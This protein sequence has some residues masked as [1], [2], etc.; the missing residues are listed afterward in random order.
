MGVASAAAHPSAFLGADENGWGLLADRALYHAHA[1]VGGSYG[2]RFGTG[3][4]VGCELDCEAGTLSFAVNGVPCGVAFSGLT[5]KLYPAVGLYSEGTR[6]TLLP[7]HVDTPGAGV[8]VAGAPSHVVVEELQ[9]V[10]SVLRSRVGLAQHHTVTAAS[11]PPAFA[12]ALDASWLRW[13]AGFERRALTKNGYELSF[14]TDPRTIAALAG[15]RAMRGQLTLLSRSARS[16]EMLATTPELA[17]LLAQCV[18][19]AGDRVRFKPRPAGRS[20]RSPSSFERRRSGGAGAAARVATAASG[21]SYHD[22]APSRTHGSTSR[23]ACVTVPEEDGD[24]DEDALSGDGSESLNGGGARAGAAIA[25]ASVASCDD[26]CLSLATSAEVA[27]SAAP[28]SAGAAPG[29]GDEEHADSVGSGSDA[30]TDSDDES[31]EADDDDD[32]GDDDAEDDEV[33]DDEEDAANV[34]AVRARKGVCEGELIG[35]HGG[36]LWM[37]AD[38]DVGAW[39]LMTS[40]SFSHPSDTVGGK[41]RDSQPETLQSTGR[42]PPAGACLQGWA[43]GVGAGSIAGETGVSE[44]ALA[45]AGQLASMLY[46]GTAAA[47]SADGSDTRLFQ[48]RTSYT[49]ASLASDATLLAAVAWSDACDAALT[50]EV[51]SI[52]SA[53]TATSTANPWNLSPAVIGTLPVARSG[54][55]VNPSSRPSAAVL[56]RLEMLLPCLQPAGNASVG[57][58]S[59]SADASAST[60]HAETGISVASLTVGDLRCIVTMAR[61]AALRLLNDRVRPLLPFLDMSQLA[62]AGAATD[63]LLPVCG[64]ITAAASG[65]GDASS[66][67]MASAGVCASPLCPDLLRSA[68]SARHLLFAHTKRAVLASVLE[69]TATVPRKP[70]DEFEFPSELPVVCVNRLRAVAAFNRAKEAAAA[71]GKGS[72]KQAEE[73]GAS[74][75]DLKLLSQSVFGQLFEALHPLSGPTLRLSFAHPM[76]DG[77]YRAFRVKLEGEGSDDYS[78]PYRELFETVAQE[79]LATAAASGDRDGSSAS[80]ADAPPSCLLPFFIPVPNASAGVGDNR[81]W[82]MLSPVPCGAQ[83]VHV[84]VHVPM[85]AS[86]PSGASAGAPAR[87]AAAG[88]GGSPS[89]EHTHDSDSESQ[90]QLCLVRSTLLLPDSARSHLLFL[91]QLLGMALRSRLQLPL[92]LAPSF[93]RS[94]AMQ[95]VTEVHLAAADTALFSSL[96]GIGAAGVE[97]ACAVLQDALAQPG[98]PGDSATGKAAGAFIEAATSAAEF[99]S[100]TGS[101][102]PL[103][104][105]SE[106]LAA[107][108]SIVAAGAASAGGAG[109][110]AHAAANAAVLRLRGALDAPI[111]GFEDLTWTAT[112]ASGHEV[113]LLL[114]RATGAPAAVTLRHVL[115]GSYRAAVVQSRL[116][117]TAAVAE[118]VRLGVTSVVPAAVLP[119]LTGHE[120]SVALSG[121]PDISIDVLEANAEYD[122]GLMAGDE[123]IRV[124]WRV[125]R[126]LSPKEKALFLRFVWGRSSLPPSAS[127]WTQRFKI[128]DMPLP[129]AATVARAAAAEAAAGAAADALRTS[130]LAAVAAAGSS[131]AL[132]GGLPGAALA[133]AGATGPVLLN[134]PQSSSAAAALRRLSFSLAASA[135]AAGSAGSVAGAT[136]AALPVAGPASASAS[137]PPSPGSGRRD[138]LAGQPS[139]PV[140]AGGAALAQQQQQQQLLL[141]RPGS[142]RPPT[143]SL[144][145][146]RPSSAMQGQTQP[147][148]TEAAAGGSGAGVIAV[149]STGAAAGASAPAISARPVSAFRPQSALP[150]H[151]TL[152][153]AAGPGRRSAAVSPIDEPIIVWPSARTAP[154]AASGD[155]PS[156]APSLPVAASSS[157][158]A[159]AA[160]DGMDGLAS[161]AG[162]SIMGVALSPAQVRA[163]AAEH[164]SA[165]VAAGPAPGAT[166]S[167]PLAPSPAF[168]AASASS[169]SATLS[170]TSM[171]AAADEGHLA[172]ARSRLV[173]G[174]MFS[175]HVC[176]FAL[177]VPRQLDESVM[178]RNLLL[179]IT[180]CVAMD[181]DYR[182][183]GRDAEDAADWAT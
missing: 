106:G 168:G 156:G 104:L 120:L 96:D 50:Q 17:H 16:T 126:S 117:E 119:L 57:G 77:L 36:C 30:D 139:R 130:S 40:A 21:A 148:T 175:A 46:R 39:S 34:Q 183:S 181:G 23:V 115:D 3:D 88:A 121:S 14:E 28:A 165:D 164:L 171:A 114:D 8:T 9:L 99:A 5:G 66:G 132:V 116:S 172:I 102:I 174:Q 133:V 87:G 93:W 13:A 141:Q 179:A 108:E 110:V 19:L 70:E 157:G 81:E 125:L 60:A 142:A 29:I 53:P 38:G 44:A 83:L 69:R 64:I 167:V 79:L 143:A 72:I 71:S 26:D 122:E 22:D 82:F 153:A 95:P 18:P 49:V 90:S 118:V 32:E 182:V 137:G 6:L 91:G 11:L 2:I 74:A 7:D 75:A 131:S 178:R 161:L 103:R 84:P 63:P 76:D 166:A 10:A 147:A 12:A 80:S 154:L 15:D 58:N 160:G 109:S 129:D 180:E 128:Q 89:A 105:C 176:F 37:H 158:A 134:R 107:V 62:C 177:R 150:A 68:T 65:M 31:D 145:P 43:E 155:G 149:A 94:L 78:G 24:L 173:N 27:S 41:R 33:D 98:C 152:A 169:S 20:M 151:A 47:A 159:A 56:L 101:S 162:L 42:W 135:V 124:F 85:P 35:V 163:A 51:A 144:R 52:C 48:A 4:I 127:D 140:T 54:A 25:A 100:A 92:P 111:P 61:F 97:A 86:A 1:K 170:A 59:A 67:D 73:G 112:W 138:P 136:S 45:R 146:T 55:L 123:H 113:P